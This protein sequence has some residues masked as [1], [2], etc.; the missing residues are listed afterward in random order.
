MIASLLFAAAEISIPELASED[1]LPFLPVI[2]LVTGATL[3]LLSEVFLTGGSRGHQ[4]II[5]AV[6]AV[7]AGGLAFRN[8]LLPPREVMLRFGVLD[9]FSSAL[10]VILCVGL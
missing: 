6:S 8:V 1:L 7:T 4:P 5:G 10:T 9:P 2:A 3:L